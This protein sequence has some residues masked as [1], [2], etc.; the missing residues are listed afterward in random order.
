V[1]VC[2][3]RRCLLLLVGY[4]INLY[5]CF[6]WARAY[7]ELLSLLAFTNGLEVLLYCCPIAFSVVF[8]ISVY[9]PPANPSNL[10]DIYY[11]NSP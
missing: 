11:W 3:F 1:K 2:C 10:L 7:E 4:G 6:L 8:F 9:Y 5:L